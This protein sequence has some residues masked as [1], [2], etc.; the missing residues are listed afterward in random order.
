M[1]TLADGLKE[2]RKECNLQQKDIAEELGGADNTISRWE[3]GENSPDDQVIIYLV[4]LLVVTYVYLIGA[5]DVPAEPKMKPG[6][7]Q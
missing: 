1:A 4:K 3:R 7:L 2:I 6:D 5:T